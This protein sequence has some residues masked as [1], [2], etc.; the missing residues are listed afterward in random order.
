[1]KRL[2]MAFFAVAA[3]TGCSKSEVNNS[4]DGEK[5]PFTIYV[6]A[7]SDNGTKTSFDESTY[8][9]TW[10]KGDALAVKV[11]NG[12]TLYKFVNQ[13]GEDNA[14]TCTDF[15]PGEGEHTYEILYPYGDAD[16]KFTMSGGIKTP[17]YGTATATGSD[18]P[19]VEMKQLSAI[20]KV[21][22]K[23]D[24]ESGT[25]ALSS[26]R[27]ERADGGVL[28]GKHQ[29]VEG[30]AEPV[31]G[32]TVSY[33]EVNGQSKKIAAGASVDMYLQCAPFTAE[34]GTTLN[35]KYTVNGKEYSAE[36]TFTKNVEFVAGKVNRTTVSFKEEADKKI[37]VDFGKT[38]TAGWNSV[39]SESAKDVNLLYLDGTESGI[40]LSVGDGWGQYSYGDN[41]NGYATYNEVQYPY[42]A[43]SD[44][45]V[46]DGTGEKTI[47]FSGLDSGKSYKFTI[48]A[49]RWNG[50][51]TA[52]ATN[53]WLVG[54]STTEMKKVYQGTKIDGVDSLTK[55]IEDHFAVFENVT[56][57]ADGKVVLNATAG[58]TTV[59]QGALISAVVI[60]VAE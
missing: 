14:F 26:L 38:S 39:T 51:S 22:V 35:I 48:A 16:F 30:K 46:F 1:M 7:S 43:W 2:F 47:T 4:A 28:G 52:R 55:N 42:T 40:S 23:N 8:A 58:I 5:T 45:F 56:P 20:I 18:A 10:V 15:T 36:K 49:F 31:S 3:L 6:S 32:S 41:K 53:Y 34:T 54:A 21:T 13:T 17:M 59:A 9:V 33:T 60:E 50:T 57:D 37:Y 25:A 27:I 11:D 19:E 44:S 12:E 24:S 29:I